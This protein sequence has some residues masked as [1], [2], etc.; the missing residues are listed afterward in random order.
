MRRV[1]ARMLANAGAAAMAA[2]RDAHDPRALCLCLTNVLK[3]NCDR[4]PSALFRPRHNPDRAP[5]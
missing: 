3:R 4:N 5:A 2:F 1:Y